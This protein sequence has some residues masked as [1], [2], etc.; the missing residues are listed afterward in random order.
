M[1]RRIILVILALASLFSMTL[2]Q[3][4]SAQDAKELN[5]LGVLSIRSGN[6]A[7]AKDYLQ[8][9]MKLNPTWAEPYY[10]A[11][12]LLKAVQKRDDMKRMLK[13]AHDLEPANQSYRDEFSKA[14]KEDM[15]A[16]K[17]AGDAAKAS[18]LREE[19][20]RVDPTETDLGADMVEEL[21]AAKQAEKAKAL[22][23]SLIEDNKSELPQYRSEGIGRLF[24]HLGKIEFDANNVAK[25]REY[26]E[27]A[28]RYPLPNLDL[29]K[30]LVADI[31]KN[32]RDAAEGHIKLGRSYVEK[33]DTAKA[34]EEFETA[35]SIDVGNETAKSEIESLQAKEES[36]D[37]MAEALKMASGEKWLEARDMLEQVIRAQPKHDEA[38]KLLAKAV[39]FETELMKKLGRTERLP[40]STQE[41]AALTESF[42]SMGTRFAGAGNNKDAKTAFE[43]ALALIALDSKLEKYKSQADDE[44][45]KIGSID[46]RKQTW[47]KGKEQYKSGEY[48]ECIKSL[49]S[50]PIDY[51]VDL[52]SFLSYCYWKNGNI[53]KAKE[54]ANRQ[55]AKQADNNR[56]KFVLGNIYAGVGDNAAAYKI[57]K[58]VK[59]ADPE[60]PGIDDVLYKAGAF[61]WGP[62]VVPA[63]AILILCWI[64]WII[65]NNLPEYNKNAAIKR[66][67]AFLNKGC[68][69]ESID[70]LNA[71]RRLPNLDLYDGA[72]ISRLSAQ[73][74]LKTGAYDRAIGECKHLISI[75]PQDAEAHQWLGFA[76]LGRRMLTPESLPELLNL[77]KTENRN[78]ALVSLLGQ[79]YTGQKTLSNDGIEILEKWLELE[80]NNPEVLK[81]LGK[82]YLQKGRTDE[83]AMRV[84]QRMMEFVKLEPEFLLG[85]AKLHLR[86]QQNEDCLRL[87]EQVIQMDVNNEM[88]HAVL[89]DCY[90]KME[91]LPELIDIYRA[92]LA[93]N[94]YN[95]AFQ[96]GLTEAMKM[97]TRAGIPVVTGPAEQS[98]LDDPGA[99]SLPGAQPPA[100]TGE[101]ISCPHC[102]AAN[103]KADYYCQQCGKSIV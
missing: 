15:R 19:I 35:M 18:S 1:N 57:L 3:P 13:K 27:K 93:E 73:A 72:M 66:A 78:I 36:R 92:F 39:A 48:E 52:L 60:Y 103:S 69:R 68:Y 2:A 49:E 97:A 38:R 86:Q 89:R 16:A 88:V 56:A 70:E 76:Y 87:C 29:G 32:Q 85:V 55:L 82:F 44:M 23:L 71:I 28:T 94:P 46:T 51:S 81:P 33:G 77:Y 9:A 50:L 61:N 54:L 14:L 24:Y 10:N 34:I 7:E 47:E 63:V 84:F 101:G 43:R 11:A 22:A 21:V 98:A 30:E 91:K 5:R 37:L 26:A 100:D 102:G 45:Q 95:V 12:L 80:P 90:Q 53:D 25:A 42:I 62:V 6:Y 65:Y 75:N 20:V 83:N 64:G 58:E 74:F 59:D 31:R 4:L 99:Q 17:S 41:R 79:H 96:K 8:K 40:R 67:R